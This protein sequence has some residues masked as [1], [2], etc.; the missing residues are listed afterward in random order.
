VV[1]DAVRLGAIA[2]V[3]VTYYLTASS[4]AQRDQQIIR[5]KLGDY[6]A[7]Y[8]R[9]GVRALASTVR[10]EQQVAPERLFV[11]RR[12]SRRRIGRAQQP[13]R[14]GSVEARD[15]LGAARRRHAG[16]GR[17]EHRGARG[18]AGAIRADARLV[19]LLIVVDR[20]D[21]RLAGDAVGA[22]SDP[23]AVAGGAADHPHRPHRRARAADGSGDALDELTSL[24]NTMLDKIEGLVT[25]M[26][27][28][29]DNVSH[30]LR[31]PLTRLRGTAELALASPPDLRSLPRGAGRLRRG[32]R[33][34]AGDAQHADG[35]LGGRERRDAAAA[36]AGQTG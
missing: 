36:R 28:A 33:P 20:A 24:F 11:P 29:L 34:R 21:R 30:D 6:A 35:H 19:T 13:R 8:Q 9:G 23:A 7:A 5:G 17:E 18:S 10:A 14:L 22:L 25:S 31:T 3:F 32:V 27:G 26:R 15:R 16:A 1:R 2:I 4:L 12:R